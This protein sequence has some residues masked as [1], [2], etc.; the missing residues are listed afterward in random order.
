MTFEQPKTAYNAQPFQPLMLHLVDGREIPVEHRE[1]MAAS[2]CGRSFAVY[3]P[4]D[5]ADIIDLHLVSDAEI[6]PAKNGSS[7]RRKV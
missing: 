1:F 7:E 3:Q 6:R 2:P 5:S 4:D